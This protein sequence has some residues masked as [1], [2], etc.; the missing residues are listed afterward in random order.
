LAQFV[1]EQYPG[2]P[3]KALYALDLAHFFKLQSSYRRK[4]QA[5]LQHVWHRGC[6]LILKKFKW[7]RAPSEQE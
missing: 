4:V 6:I 3:G 1:Q 7:L 5:L 2:E